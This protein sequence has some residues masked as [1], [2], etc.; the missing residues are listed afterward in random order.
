MLFCALLVAYPVAGPAAQ[1]SAPA[2]I[3]DLS[4]DE[5]EAGEEEWEDEDDTAWSSRGAVKVRL[6]DRTTGPGRG[7]HK[8]IPRTLP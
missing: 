7:S 8:D 5:E 3:Q 2:N 4:E 1:A 6:P